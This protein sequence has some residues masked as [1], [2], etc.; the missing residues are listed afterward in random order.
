[1]R[2][3]LGPAD[4]FCMQ[5][6]MD[7]SPFRQ[8]LR[9]RTSKTS[10]SPHREVAEAL[11]T[12]LSATLRDFDRYLRNDFLIAQM[13]LEEANYVLDQ[14]AL[15]NREAEHYR[16]EARI[17]NR[18]TERLIAAGCRLSA[19]LSGKIMGRMMD[20]LENSDEGLRAINLQMRDHIRNR[21]LSTTLLHKAQAVR[22]ETHRNAES[23]GLGVI[24]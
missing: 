12:R 9:P 4:T 10:L 18:D 24:L 23:S 5:D 2:P 17:P 13:T 21:H 20:V 19:D 8:T 14:I 11:K 1:M 6:A 7:T 15:F 22:N 16:A 3:F